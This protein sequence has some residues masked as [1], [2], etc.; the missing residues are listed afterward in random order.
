M[1]DPPASEWSTGEEVCWLFENQHTIML[2][3]DP[4][5]FKIIDANPAACQFYGYTRTQLAA[6]KITDLNGL[7]LEQAAQAWRAWQD[8]PR[9]P[10]VLK[11]RLANGEVRDVEAYAGPIEFRGQ[12]CQYSIVHDITR[13]KQVEDDLQRERNFV[14][15]VLDTVGALVV[16]LDRAGNIVR[17]NRACER[18]TG[19]AADEV[20]HR[21]LWDILLTPEELDAVRTVFERLRAGDFPLDFENYWV[22]K[23]H[24]RRLIAWSNT[25]LPADDGSIEYVIGTGVDITERHQ[26]EQE[27]KRISS[28]PLLNP[29]PVLEVDKTGAVS[30]C[31]PSALRVLEQQKQSAQVRLFIPADWPAIVSELDRWPTEVIRREVTIGELMFA[32]SIH[33][34]QGFGTIRIFAIDITERRQAEARLRQSNAELQARNAELDAFAHSVAHDIKN[35][36]HIITGYAELLMLTTDRSPD[37]LLSAL[38]AIRKNAQKINSITDSLMLLAEVRQKALELHPIDMAA[39]LDEVWLRVT[40]LLD[41]QVE[42]RL[43]EVWPRA[44]GYAPWIEEVWANYLGNALKYASRPG[45]IELGA[46]H[47]ADGLIR[48]WVRDDGIGIAPAEQAHL[49]TAFYQTSRARPGG[50]GLGLSIVKRIVER[51]GG[52]VG[53]ISTGVPGDGST[54]SFTLP[55]ASGV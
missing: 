4:H 2:I 23:D 35:P 32:E 25:V 30:F 48:F 14:S 17:F 16:V 34:A 15:T 55:A 27:I 28:F 44:L 6:L 33:L 21:H 50:H 39:I 1:I 37:E 40:H 29:N 26:A 22:T 46:T 52:T 13:R 12:T 31:N 3:Y 36:L 19:Y 7:S 11:H 41:G 54:F 18:L 5:T 47:E 8:A 9:Q 24:R 43:P 45:C 53:V 42:V 51:L 49:F 10:Y 38:T 20:L